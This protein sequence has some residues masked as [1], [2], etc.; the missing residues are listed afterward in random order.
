MQVLFSAE[1]V[2]PC[3]NPT[4]CHEDLL[5]QVV[6]PEGA[7][8]ISPNVPF[9]ADITYDT[10]C[11]HSAPCC[12]YGRVHV[13]AVVVFEIIVSKLYPLRLQLETDP[14][15]QSSASARGL[16]TYKV[17]GG[18]SGPTRGAKT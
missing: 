17:P 12:T 3:P 6:L 5:L 13:H 8:D 9:E 16:A 15:S 10:K 18:E 2:A 1:A 14:W 11:A 7:Y 4:R